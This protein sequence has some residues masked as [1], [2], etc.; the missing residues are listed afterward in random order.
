[1]AKRFLIPDT[2]VAFSVM[3]DPK[4]LNSFTLYSCLPLTVTGGSVSSKVLEVIR[5]LLF[6]ELISIPNANAVS[7]KRFVSPSCSFMLPAK[8]SMPSAN[9]RLLILCSD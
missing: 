1:M 8:R 6:F 2:N 4:Y 7:S 5:I 9:C 3:Y